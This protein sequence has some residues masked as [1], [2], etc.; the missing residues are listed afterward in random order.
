MMDQ[1]GVFE[2]PAPVSAPEDTCHDRCANLSDSFIYQT[3]GLITAGKSHK[4]LDMVLHQLAS[5]GTR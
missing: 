4:V 2:L 1:Y 3:R 5:E